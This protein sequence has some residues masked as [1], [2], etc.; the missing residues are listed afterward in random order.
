M[1]NLYRLDIKS[2]NIFNLW[3]N[4]LIFIWLII[5]SLT[6]F[7]LT[8]K[9]DNPLSKT[10]LSVTGGGQTVSVHLQSDI[11]NTV[12]KYL[13]LLGLRKENKKLKQENARLTAEN[14]LLKELE[15]E[16]NKLIQFSGFSKKEPGHLLSARVVAT[17]LL[18]QNQMLVIDKGSK[19]GVRKY[20]GVIHPTGVIGHVFKTAPSSSQVITLFNRLSSLPVINQRSRTKGVVE[21]GLKSKTLVLKYFDLQWQSTPDLKAGDRIVTEETQH[22]RSGFPVGIIHS[23]KKDIS[24]ARQTVFVKLSAPISAAEMVFVNLKPQNR[25]QEP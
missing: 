22:F 7:L 20:M 6:A 4:N 2:M 9:Q 17:D 11:I 14:Q 1:L 10:I 12:K 25:P 16:H 24:T 15:Y 3:R 13:F 21:T 5:I 23:I 18:A 19:H 8:Q